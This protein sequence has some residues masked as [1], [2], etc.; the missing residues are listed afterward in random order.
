MMNF[1][2]VAIHD[3]WELSDAG[4]CFAYFWP[5]KE[6]LTDVLYLN[7]LHSLLAELNFGEL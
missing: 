6:Y 2:A 4:S 5:F 3:G 7:P 1:H